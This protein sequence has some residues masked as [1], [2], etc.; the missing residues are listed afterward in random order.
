MDQVIHRVLK[1]VV[2]VVLVEVAFAMVVVAR[3]LLLGREMRVELDKV[4]LV[5]VLE[6]EA[7]ERLGQ[8]YRL[9]GPELLAVLVYLLL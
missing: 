9:P 8:L 4:Q 2:L 6:A 1:T 5:L 7:L 3:P